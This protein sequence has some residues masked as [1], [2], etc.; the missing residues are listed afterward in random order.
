[1]HTPTRPTYAGPALFSYGFR[2][3]FLAAGLFAALIVPLWMM[4]WSGQV[5]LS[6]PFSPL[7]WHIHEMLFGYTSAVIAGFLFTAIPNWTG[8]MPTRGQPLIA[9]AVLWIA[10][11]LAVAFAPWPLLVMAVD[12]AFLLAIGVMVVTEIVAGRNWRNLMVVLPV[13]AYLAANIA[14]HL[15]AM[16]QGSAEIGRRLGFAMVT[17]LIALI[18][19]RIIPSFTRNWLAKRG[20]GPMPVPFGRFDALCLAGTLA[21]LLTWV[22]APDTALAGAGLLAAG[23]LQAGRLARWRGIRVWRSPLLAMLHLAFAFIPAG[24]AALGLAALGVWP[25]VTGLHLL[26]I[27]GIGGMTLAVMIRASLGHTAR[28]LVAGR[29]LTLGFACVALAALV[30]VAVPSGA[31]LWG[32]AGLWVVGFGLFLWRFAPIL[33]QPNP[34]RRVPGGR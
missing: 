16:G 17:L 26:G 3:L 34:A 33:T 12:C 13:L 29:A 5:A 31:G 19:G 6:G 11:R 10:G 20:P 27:G 9:L 7:D 8:R 15:E 30:R 14:F 23:A 22:A 28:E 2:P 18:G 24:L 21:A 1:M 32:A 4:V 25:A